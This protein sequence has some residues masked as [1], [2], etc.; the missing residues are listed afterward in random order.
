VHPGEVELER[1]D[2]VAIVSLTGEHDLTTAQAVRDCVE[3]ALAGEGGLV[4]SLSAAEFIDS[5]IIGVV[6]DAQRQAEEAG[7]GFATVLE[8]GAA[9]VR[10]V[11]EVTGLDSNLPVRDNRREAIAHA[12]AGRAKADG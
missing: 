8:G 6:L 5:S 1:T 2:G 10:R 9:P 3:E 11:L 12:S 4:M 7:V